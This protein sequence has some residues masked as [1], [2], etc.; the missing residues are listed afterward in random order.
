MEKVQLPG[1]QQM[2]ERRR[3]ERRQ[4]EGGRRA[5]DRARP[6]SAQVQAAAWAIIG[7]VVVL[8]LFLLALNA[9]SP[10]QAPV[11]TAIILVLA[12]AW[13]AHS[14]RRLLGGGFVS[15]PDRERRGF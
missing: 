4:D 1:G 5:T 10:G 8:F 2:P 14:W 11:A 15:R 7:S 9:F 3:G 13:L 6:R 12:V